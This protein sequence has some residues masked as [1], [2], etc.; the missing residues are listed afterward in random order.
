MPRNPSR[1]IISNIMN[2]EKG[3][4]F[5]VVSAE[6]DYMSEEPDILGVRDK[7]QGLC[8]RY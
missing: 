7:I 6:F 5:T 1:N 2:V 8:Q 3:A 4:L